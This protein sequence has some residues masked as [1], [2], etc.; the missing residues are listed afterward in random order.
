MKLTPQHLETFCRWWAMGGGEKIDYTV[1]FYHAMKWKFQAVD[2][3]RLQFICFAYYRSGYI[4]D[5][6]QEYWNKR[7]LPFIKLKGGKDDQASLLPPPP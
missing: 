7:V 2:P 4:P 1:F 6:A 5:F 3:K